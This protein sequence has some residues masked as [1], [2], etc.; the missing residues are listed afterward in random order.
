MMNQ[1]SAGDRARRMPSL[2]KLT[3]V[4]AG[5]G[6]LVLATGFSAQAAVYEA[7]PSVTAAG[8]VQFNNLGDVFTICDEASDVLL[9]KMSSVQV[10]RHVGIRGGCRRVGRVVGCR[11]G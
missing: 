2:V 7:V 4:V 10:K 11:G 1:I 8:V 9:P 5:A 3:A 6:G